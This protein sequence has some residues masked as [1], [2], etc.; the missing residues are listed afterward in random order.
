MDSF[1]ITEGLVPQ[2]QQNDQPQSPVSIKLTEE[3]NKF[4]RAIAA[5][6]GNSDRT[7]H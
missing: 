4:Q 5:W 2:D 3:T 1:A 6:R 7:C